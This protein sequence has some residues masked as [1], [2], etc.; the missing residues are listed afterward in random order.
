MLRE[1]LAA[2]TIPELS[3]DGWFQQ[4]A[5]MDDGEPAPVSTGGDNCEGVTFYRTRPPAVD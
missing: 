4:G 1:R 3:G 5:R 2:H